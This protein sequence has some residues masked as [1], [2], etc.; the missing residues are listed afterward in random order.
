[1]NSS[2]SVGN[3]GAGG[4][5][6]AS[7]KR[8]VTFGAGE[9][10]AG[11][12]KFGGNDDGAV[13]SALVTNEQVD[14][15]LS[16]VKRSSLN[17][18]IRRQLVQGI[19]L[20]LA[21]LAAAPKYVPYQRSRKIKIIPTCREGWNGLDEN[22]IRDILFRL[23]LR[24][25]AICV[26]KIC[27]AWSELK[28]RAPGLFVDL[29]C[30]SGP[31]TVLQMEKFIKWIPQRD[32]QACTSLR[33]STSKECSQWS[34]GS[35]LTMLSEIKHP[36]LMEAEPDSDDE[37]GQKE[38]SDL[39]SRSLTDMKKLF[40]LGPKIKDDVIPLLPYLGVGPSLTH[41]SVDSITFSTGRELAWRLGGYLLKFTALQVL[42]IPS[43]LVPSQGLS[44]TLSN[45]GNGENLRILDLTKE[46]VRIPAGKEVSLQCL[47]HSLHS[48]SQR[49]QALMCFLKFCILCR[50]IIS[51]GETLHLLVN[52]VPG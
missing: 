8:R 47:L 18:L 12:E 9:A 49:K 21:D 44:Q 37:E 11:V 19:P 24:E 41:F 28:G 17:D 26:G 29:S 1:M 40:L 31:S 50:S 36:R 43:S 4:G 27:K 45:I 13:S 20:T 35:A 16:H 25:R 39:R 33:I 10:E 7:K 38:M 5:S 23:N 48:S 2:Q 46:T 42:E 14:L 51:I 22:L 52:I 30:P 32:A 34:T 15:Y 6:R 3:D